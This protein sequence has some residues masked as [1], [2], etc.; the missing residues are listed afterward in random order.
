MKQHLNTLFV[1]TQGSYLRKDG[2]TVDVRVEK[3]TRLRVPL[4]NLSSIVCFGRVSLSPALMGTCAESGIAISFLKTNGRFLAR[5]IGPASGNV[6][7]RRAQYR[8]SD[9][10]ERCLDVSKSIVIG[11]I[12]NCRTVLRRAARDTN[13]S[14]RSESLTR[15]GDRLTTSLTAVDKSTE[16]NQLRGIEGDAASVYFAAF[17]SMLTNHAPEFAFTSR[18]RRPPLDPINALMSFAYTLLTHDVRS[19]CDAVG[20]DSQV[21]FLHRDRPGRP[22]MALDLMEEFRPVLADRMVLSLV[23]RQQIQARDFVQRESGAVLLNDAG[24]KVF[25]SSWQHRKQET[26]THPFLGEK[27]TVGLLPHIQAQLMAR[28]LRGDL[29]LYPPFVWR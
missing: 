28:H 17:N 3:Q 21:G 10:P 18:S 2:L 23:N 19:A 20:L 12:A 25:L 1:T 15:G 6:L 11:K 9:N 24:R 29:E 26:I 7:L 13:D 27:T 4:H 22:G 16:Q 5:V 8:M 14:A